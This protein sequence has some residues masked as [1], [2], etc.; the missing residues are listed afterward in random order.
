[1]IAKRFLTTE[2]AAIYTGWSVAFFEKARTTG[3]LKGRRTGGPP[4][5]KMGRKV[6]YDIN[7][8]DQWILLHRNDG[9]T[10]YK[11]KR[12]KR[13]IPK[14]ALDNIMRRII[15]KRLPL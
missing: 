12:W 6:V 3:R 9:A 10:P 1:M 13:P 2:D 7:D 11:P 4:Y 14:K 15:S 5:I 8:L